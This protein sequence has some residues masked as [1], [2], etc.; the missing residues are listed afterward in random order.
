VGDLFNECGDILE[1]RLVYNS[2]Q[3]HFKGFG[4]VDFKTV[5]GA[6]NALGMNGKMF[7][8]RPLR[9]DS[10]SKRPRGG[11]KNKMETTGNATYNS[12]T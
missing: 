3:G 7:K 9:I 12:E 2:V 8:G 10:E 6:R 1:V 4:Y 11:F 5:N